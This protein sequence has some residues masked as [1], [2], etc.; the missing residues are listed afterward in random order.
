[1][2]PCQTVLPLEIDFIIHKRPPYLFQSENWSFTKGTLL[3]CEHQIFDRE[4]YGLDLLF[5]FSQD[6]MGYF[7]DTGEQ[8]NHLPGRALPRRRRYQRKIQ[9][10]ALRHVLVI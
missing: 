5:P 6:P 10:L 7:S 1:M 8:L 2:R 9:G 4:T 3:E